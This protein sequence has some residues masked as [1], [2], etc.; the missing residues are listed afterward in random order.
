MAETEI[1]FYTFDKVFKLNDTLNTKDFF[2]NNET[3]KI[4]VVG[5]KVDVFKQNIPKDIAENFNIS[6]VSSNLLSFVD[7]TVSKGEVLKTITEIFRCDRK[8]IIAFGDQEN[9]LEMLDC[10][11]CSIA[12]CNAKEEVKNRAKFITDSNND[13][14][15][16]KALTKIFKRELLLNISPKTNKSDEKLDKSKEY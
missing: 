16:A 13:N 5:D 3:Y 15:V 1:R 14:R 11:D 6:Q 12:V 4:I 8:N 9:D 7:K 10:A 2:N